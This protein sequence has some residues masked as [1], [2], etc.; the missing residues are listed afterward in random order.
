MQECAAVCRLSGRQ[1]KQ[2]QLSEKKLLEII[3]LLKEA[4]GISV[5]IQG[6]LAWQGRSRGLPPFNAYLCFAAIGASALRFPGVTQVTQQHALREWQ[7]WQ[8]MH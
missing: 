7:R 3:G 2:L 4:E 8:L 6:T 5:P 1:T